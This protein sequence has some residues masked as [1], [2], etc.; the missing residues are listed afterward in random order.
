[1]LYKYFRFKSIQLS[2]LFADEREE[3]R[4]SRAQINDLQ[5]ELADA[6][7][8]APEIAQLTESNCKLSEENASLQKELE[9]LRAQLLSKQGTFLLLV[10]EWF[11][12]SFA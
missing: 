9:G 12:F 4:K 8:S 1:M 6:G 2:V 5:K 10:L 11:L 7:P 3:L